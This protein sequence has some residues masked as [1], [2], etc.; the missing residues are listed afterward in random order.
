VTRG[1]GQ[2]RGIGDRHRL[3]PADGL[4][5]FCFASLIASSLTASLPDSF[6]E[7]TTIDFAPLRVG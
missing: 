2:R 6:G 3:Q 7:T 5:P 1:L 4:E